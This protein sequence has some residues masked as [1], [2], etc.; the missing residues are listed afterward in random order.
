[1]PVPGYGVMAFDE[2]GLLYQGFGGFRR[3]AS[4]DLERSL[5][6]NQNTRFRTASISKVFSAVGVMQ[7]CEQGKVDLDADVSEYLGFLLRNPHYPD[8]PITLRMLMSHTSSVR[9]GNVY[10]IPPEDRIEELLLPGGKY[11]RDGDHFADS[12]DGV[13]RSP[14]R[15]F[16]YANLNYGIIGTMF[17]RLS[18]LRFDE[19]MRRNVLVPMGL[20]A[21]FN[22]GDFQAEDLWNLSP[23]YQSKN[24]ERWDAFQPWA[25]QI[26]DYCDQP[27]PH[28]QVLITNPDLG[29]ENVLADLS[30]YRIGDN[31]TLF[32]PQGGLRISCREMQQLAELLLSGGCIGGKRLLSLRSVD[33]MFTPCWRYDEQ[34][35]NGDTYGGLMCCYG[36][37]IH[38]MTSGVRDR[39][40][41]SRNV[42]L[43]GHFGEAYGLLAGL[44]LNRK[45]GCGIFYVINGQG[46]PDSDHPGQYSGMYRWEER[47]CTALLDHLFPD[48]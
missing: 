46:A 30:S 11:N 15:F 48:L 42:V 38:T 27:Q 29:G 41:R 10:S 45:R 23:I 18:G 43:S 32:S 16:S 14:G 22:V 26:D 2:G 40:L 24:G 8:C 17:E 33:T 1:M 9:D 19:Y 36:P 37:G 13:D 5:P 20:G 21:S 47:L 39:F 6:F 44:F 7:L 28:D 25:A 3:I 31:G 35:R 12:F 34:L 4:G